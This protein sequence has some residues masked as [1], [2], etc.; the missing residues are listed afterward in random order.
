MPQSSLA[1]YPETQ[2]SSNE[3]SVNVSAV[4]ALCDGSG[5]EVFGRGADLTVRKCRHLAP[6]QEVRVRERSRKMLA[7]GDDAA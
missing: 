2:E 1:A 5:W 4:C 6:R 3:N 7:A